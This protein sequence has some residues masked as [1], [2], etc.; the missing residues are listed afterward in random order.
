MI[1]VAWKLYT[2][3][4]KESAGAS[5]LAKL[6]RIDF[7]GAILFP[8]SITCGL[9]VL[10]LIGERMAWTDPLILTLLGASLVSGYC[11]LLVEAF[12]AKEPII[13]LRLLRNRDVITSYINLGF[14]SGAQI[15]MML[16]VPIYFQVSAHASVTNAGAH[17]MPSVMGNAVGGILSG[18]WIKRSAFPS[19]ECGFLQQC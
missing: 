1:L 14:Q 4:H 18:V 8:I 13:P 10:E 5:Q 16:L 3:P 19:T 17:L 7:L 6:R 11:F 15:A 9:L 12:W 2:P